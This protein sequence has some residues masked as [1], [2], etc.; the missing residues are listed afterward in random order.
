MNNYTELLTDLVNVDVKIDEEDKAM[1]QLNSLPDEEY[2]IFT[3][4]LING[5]QTIDNSDVSAALVNYEV[6]RQNK[7]SSSEG[8]SAEA[9][10][11]RDRSSNRKGRGDHERSKSRLGF[12]DLKKNQCAFCKDLGHWKIDCP[13]T[14]GKKKESKPKANLVQVV[15]THASTLQADGSDSDSSV[16]FFSITTPTIDYSG[17][18]EWVLD[19]G[20]TYHVCPNRDWFSNFEK[21]NGCFAVMGD[22]HPCKVE[23]ISTVCIKMFDGMVRKLKEVRYVP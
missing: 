5:R 12:K 7:L 14:K 1:I 15:S 11:V 8:T 10:A 3:L 6:R 20:A 17:D 18:S 21:L 13:K 4:I 22:D 2:K 16:F 19:I 23:G 9:L